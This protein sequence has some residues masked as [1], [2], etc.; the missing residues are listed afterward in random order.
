MRQPKPLVSHECEQCSA[1]FT[2]IR[3]VHRFCSYACNKKAVNDRQ[4]QRGYQAP[5]HERLCP[6]CGQPYE[7]PLA[8]RRVY[9]SAT[10]AEDACTTA[11]QVRHAGRQRQRDAHRVDCAQCGLPFKPTKSQ[12]Y[13]SPGC[14]REATRLQPESRP[15]VYCGA[16]FTPPVGH[17]GKR[18]C[19][20]TCQRRQKRD[21]H[22]ASKQMRRAQTRGAP[23]IERVYRKRIFERDGYLCLLCG[24]PLAMDEQVP[25]PDAPTID[26]VLPLS[27]GG[28][29]T[30][31]NVQAA[32]FM[33]NSR[34]HNRINTTN[35]T[36]I[37]SR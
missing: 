5:R 13:F 37:P 34:K 2:S 29:H 8:T 27:R 22:R 7:A 26:H 15:C 32:H 10:C 36:H 35:A 17:G 3:M 6:Q 23:N 28:A 30:P 18:L 9:C 4:R 12:R 33:C 11:T 1:P 19:S 21:V 14:V 31:A 25:H 20:L 24:R 16:E